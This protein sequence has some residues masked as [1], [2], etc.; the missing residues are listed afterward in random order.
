MG[1]RT[2]PRFDLVGGRLCLDFCN[3]HGSRSGANRTFLFDQF[4]QANFAR[5]ECFGALKR[6]AN[7]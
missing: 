3:T 6:N 5:P 1:A 4:Q 7:G 2:P